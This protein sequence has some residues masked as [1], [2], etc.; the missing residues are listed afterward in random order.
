VQATGPVTR[1][2]G[3]WFRGAV[4]AVCLT[5]SA[6]MSAPLFGQDRVPERGISAVE[7]CQQL[8]VPVGARAS[9]L[10]GALTARGGPDVVFI[11][12]AALAALT[13]DE[14]RIHTEKT[15]VESTTALGL[16]FRIRGAGVLGLAYRLSEYGDSEA[17]DEVGQVTGR[18][19]PLEH[20]LLAS[21]ATSM[22]PGIAAG[23]SYKTYQLRNQCE[24][25]CGGFDFAATTHAVDFGVQYHPALWPTLQLGASI[26]HL[27]LPLQVLNAEQADPTPARLRVGGAYELMHHFSADTTT[28]LWLSADLTGSWREGVQRQAAAGLELVLDH[29]IFVRGGYATGTGRESGAGIGV[30][31]RYDRFDVGIARRFG[32]GLGV[33]DPF[34]ITFSLAF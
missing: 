29:T 22:G 28:A 32:V 1:A 20:F 5:L 26:L 10:A 30:G 23:V 15:E 7:C 6:G 19:R 33:Q 16:A 25:F 24:G 18:L 12:P 14:L 31:L 21:F 34:Q 17:T 2:A 8:L 11:N 4:G 27:G 13:R 3:A 9:A